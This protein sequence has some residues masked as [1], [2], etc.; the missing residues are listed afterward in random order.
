MLHALLQ[1]RIKRDGLAAKVKISMA[2]TAS[3][4]P[5]VSMNRM[6]GSVPQMGVEVG[7]VDRAPQSD[8]VIAS[9]EESCK[10]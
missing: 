7:A 2:G 8:S 3:V 5:A 10:R 1:E 9:V 4:C 6:V